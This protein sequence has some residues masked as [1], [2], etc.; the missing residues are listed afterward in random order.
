MS[1]GKKVL[2]EWQLAG[3]VCR[4]VETEPGIVSYFQARN[5]GEP[6]SWKFEK[7]EH[8]IGTANEII[9]LAQSHDAL[10]ARLADAEERVKELEAER[11]RTRA[12]E[13]EFIEWDL[14]DRRG[15]PK[16]SETWRI[17]HDDWNRPGFLE[18]ERKRFRRIVAEWSARA[19]VREG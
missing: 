14:R 12:E 5:E 6:R 15:F 13:R 16:D 18:G 8:P 11:E 3:Y 7:V 10:A 2:H 19:A 17:I 4:I 1:E 9:H